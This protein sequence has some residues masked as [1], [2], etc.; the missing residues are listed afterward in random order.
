MNKTLFIAAMLC[1]ISFFANAQY[2]SLTIN[3]NT[4]C[5]IYLWLGGVP[6]F[7]PCGADY[8]SNVLSIPPGPTTYSDPTAVPGG[9]N[10]GGGSLGTNDKFSMAIVY[11]SDPAGGCSGYQEYAMSDCI[12][13]MQ[14]SVTTVTF[15]DASNS[16]NTCGVYDITWSGA[17]TNAVLDIN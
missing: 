17:G 11:N 7:T 8:R 13:G 12:T 2:N 15:K 16:C 9:L 5:T 10:R 1:C 6:N 4:G 14:T 3:N